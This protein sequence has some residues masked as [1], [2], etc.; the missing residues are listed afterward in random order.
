MKVKR[1][2]ASVSAGFEDFVT[3]VENHEAVADCAIDELRKAAA[4]VRDRKSVV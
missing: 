3:R 4:R 2:M 1:L